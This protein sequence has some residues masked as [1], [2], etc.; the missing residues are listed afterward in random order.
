MSVL[1][2]SF[3]ISGAEL[4]NQTEKSSFIC[5]GSLTRNFIQAQKLKQFLQKKYFSG[6]TTSLV[7]IARMQLTN[8]ITTP[9]INNNNKN[10]IIMRVDSEGSVTFADAEIQKLLNLPMTEIYEKKFWTLVHPLDE[11]NV[12]D[13]LLNILK[14]NNVVI[15]VCFKL[16]KIFFFEKFFSRFPNNFFSSSVLLFFIKADYK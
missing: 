13:A 14:N 6:I 7:L 12:K 1:E 15:K 4:K 10:Q 11:Q 9:S 5:F 3:C 2:K 16:K 8:L